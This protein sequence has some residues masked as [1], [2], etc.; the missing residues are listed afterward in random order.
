ML[1]IV[2][3]LDD[4]ERIEY[5]YSNIKHAR[6]HYNSEAHAQLVEYV[7]GNYYLMDVK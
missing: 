5:E 4:T 3:V 2:V 6:E 1:Y 7:D